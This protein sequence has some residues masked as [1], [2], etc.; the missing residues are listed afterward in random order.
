MQPRPR[1]RESGCVDATLQVADYASHA[2][3]TRVTTADNGFYVVLGA[4]DGS[5]VV[6]VIVDP[7]QHA[8]ATGLLHS[9]PSRQVDDDPSQSMS[10]AA[11]SG[12]FTAV[13]TR[14]LYSGMRPS[15]TTDII[16]LE[17]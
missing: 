14:R 16:S 13:A 15:L 1:R 8:P 6:L 9:L 12:L 5:V 7:Q 2:Q 17:H 11:M 10:A 3:I 4:V